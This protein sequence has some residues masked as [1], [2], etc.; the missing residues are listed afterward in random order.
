M[1]NPRGWILEFILRTPTSRS[2]LK[3]S[4]KSRTRR[5][6]RRGK[7]DHDL[8]LVLMILSPEAP[9]KP[10]GSILASIP[11]FYLVLN[12]VIFKLINIYKTMKINMKLGTTECI[13]SISVIQNIYNSQSVALFLNCVWFF[14]RQLTIL[15]LCSKFIFTCFDM[16][17]IVK[18]EYFWLTFW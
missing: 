11:K 13:K 9:I 2:E 1:E 4:S 5:S 15:T 6:R 10:W 14:K 18:F 8:F 17:D 16:K 3:T 12:S 7:W